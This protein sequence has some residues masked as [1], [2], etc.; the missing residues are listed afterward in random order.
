MHDTCLSQILLRVITGISKEGG[1]VVASPDA[2][3]GSWQA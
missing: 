2:Y 3:D 1:I